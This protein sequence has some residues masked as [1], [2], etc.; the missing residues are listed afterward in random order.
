MNSKMLTPQI[1]IV[2]DEPRMRF[3][4]ANYLKKAGYQVLEAKDGREALG[5]FKTTPVDLIILDIMMPHLDGFAVCAEIRKTSDTIIIMLTAKSAEEDKLFG[6]ELGA[7][8]YITKPFSPKVIIAKIN[9]LFK[10]I[11][12]QAKPHRIIQIGSLTIDEDAHS[13][14]LN[15]HKLDLSPKEYELLLYLCKN[16][17]IVLK[18]EMILDKVWG[19]DYFGDIRT[20]DTHIKRVRQKLGPQTNLI[21]T[22]RGNGYLLEAEG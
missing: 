5:L 22:V 3:L 10:R 21:T 20:V 4:I 9:T 15:N 8:D 12:A 2:E 18:R 13:V 7:D 17:G 19:F 6:Y 14:F 11:K 1:M 16:R